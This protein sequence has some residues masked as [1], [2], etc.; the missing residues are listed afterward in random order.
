MI[1]TLAYLSLALAW[2]FTSCQQN[3]PGKQF[4][5]RVDQ[6]APE[7]IEFQTIETHR[8]LP[9][10]T[11]KPSQDPYKLGA[12]DVLE[13][14]VAEVDDTLARTFVMPDGMVYYNLAGGVRAEGSTVKEF[15]KT[16]TE[17]LKK[18]YTNPIVNVSLAEIRSRRYWILGRVFKPGIY[19]LRQPTTVLEA[20]A[21]AG[22]LFTSRFSGTTEELADL[23]NSVVIRDGNILPVDF[24]KLI[25]EGDTSQNIYLRHNDFVYLPS[26]QS[27]SVMLLGA[28]NSPRAIGFKDDLSLIQCIAQ[29]RGPAPGAYIDQVVIV[30]GSVTKP[31]AAI[32]NLRA[33][34]TG[35][36]T[37]VHLKAGDIVWIPRKPL[38]LAEDT[39]ELIFRDAARAIAVNEG[40]NAVGSDEKS[41]I[42]VPVGSGQ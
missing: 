41:I 4:D 6:K 2:C 20:I 19:P 27:A 22:G 23:T 35:K 14:E 10:E 26:A 1:R 7:D 30:R 36:A 17:A 9:P 24:T 13:I 39:V 38:Q 34:L 18:D 21:E 31:Q 40:A 12:G 8:T 33:I 15:T 5:P 42:S 25:K 28:V 37:N 16:V 29:G 32:V 3:I 11:L